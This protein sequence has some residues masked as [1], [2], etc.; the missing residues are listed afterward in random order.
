M[1]DEADDWGQKK[2]EANLQL[3]AIESWGIVIGI[4]ML[5]ARLSNF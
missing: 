2:G 5:L 3:E 4:A 1:A